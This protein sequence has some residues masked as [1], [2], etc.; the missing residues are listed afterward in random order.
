M[1]QMESELGFKFSLLA[2]G[3]SGNATYIETP[4]RKILVDCGLSG[5]AM[6]ALMAKLGRN[7]SDVDTILVTHEH[8]DHIHGVGVL[9][10][11]YKMD[12]YANHE[13]W[14]AMEGKIGKLATEQK[15]IF[16]LGQMQTFGDLDVISYGVS[17]DA[18][19]PQFYAFQKDQKQFVM[20]TDTGYVSDRLRGLLKNADA[21]L[22]E[23][24]HDLEMLR[25]GGYSWSLKQRILGD[26]GHLSNDDGALATAEMVGDK[27]RRVFLG[28]LSRDNNMKTIAY[29]TAHAILR[30]KDCGLDENF[31]LYHTDPVEP[32]EL[33]TI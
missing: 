25:M 5:K 31:S 10:R 15:H 19:N 14:Q 16:E 18:A 26:K 32:T 13:T 22:I 6:E 27:T 29:D 11:K 28:H 3:S 1:M 12:V 33:F 17:H 30:D 9:A 20:L 8:S 4:Q 24:N 23:S 21:Y 2:S 7:L